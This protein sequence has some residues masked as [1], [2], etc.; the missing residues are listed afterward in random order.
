MISYVM[1]I[2]VL[3]SKPIEPIFCDADK[4]MDIVAQKDK[5]VAEITELQ[6]SEA[7]SVH[8]STK[9]PAFVSAH[10]NVERTAW[11]D[12]TQRLLYFKCSLLPI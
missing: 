10:V 3:S 9:R 5:I 4:I 2:L 8:D 11:N 7:V 12:S 6:V 1:L